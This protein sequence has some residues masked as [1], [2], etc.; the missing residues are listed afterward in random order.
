MNQVAI[1]RTIE[2]IEQADAKR[3][4]MTEYFD[5]LYNVEE[6][7]FNI[8]K[9]PACIAGWVIL[10]HNIQDD[11]TKKFKTKSDLNSNRLSFDKQANVWLGLDFRISKQ[12]FMMEL[13][14]TSPDTYR[15]FYLICTAITGRSI[16]LDK[17]GAPEDPYP[18]DLMIV[19]DELPAEYR[20]QAA[21]NVLRHLRDTGEVDWLTALKKA[22]LDLPR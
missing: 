19:F 1:Q 14:N 3:I 8:C 2:A 10:A 9:T 6:E 22:Y 12:L 17:V 16:K 4:K 5:D 7:E 11:G 13:L 18:S 15:Q 21:L 20:K